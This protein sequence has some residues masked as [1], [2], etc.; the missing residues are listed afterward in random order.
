MDFLL[1][2][3]RFSTEYQKKNKEAVKQGAKFVENPVNAFL[4]IKRLTSDWGF[5]DQLM[6]KNLA[7]GITY[8]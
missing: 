5:V 3:D 1:L 8:E 6:R 2:F 7:E 4:L